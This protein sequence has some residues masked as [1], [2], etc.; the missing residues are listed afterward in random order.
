MATQRVRSAGSRKNARGSES[1]RW[2]GRGDESDRSLPD[3]DQ[4]SLEQFNTAC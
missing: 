1:E 3:I 4:V 2:L